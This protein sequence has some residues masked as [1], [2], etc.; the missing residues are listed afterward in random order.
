MVS[1]P[2]NGFATWFDKFESNAE[3][4]QIANWISNHRNEETFTYVHW[5]DPHAPYAPKRQ[6]HH[7]VGMDPN[8]P[9]SERAYHEQVRLESGLI[10]DELV[11]KKFERDW[12][13]TMTMWP[14]ST[15]VSAY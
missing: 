13:A 2:E 1:N 11:I 10:D 5:V 8:I 9:E 4:A 15:G 12:N 7:F 6:W 3:V 14:R